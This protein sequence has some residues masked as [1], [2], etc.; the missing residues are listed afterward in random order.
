MASKNIAAEFS[1]SEIFPFNAN[2]FTEIDFFLSYMSKSPEAST[3]SGADT[4]DLILKI[5]KQMT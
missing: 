2:N 4:Q 1:K 5:F 3:T